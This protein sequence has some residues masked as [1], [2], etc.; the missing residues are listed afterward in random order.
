M[1]WT[2]IRSTLN[3]T[4]LVETRLFEPQLEGTVSISVR[5]RIAPRENYPGDR[6][7]IDFPVVEH[8]LVPVA[9]R[10]MRQPTADE[11][12]GTLATLYEAVEVK[13]GAYGIQLDLKRILEHFWR[14]R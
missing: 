4:L 11:R 5:A 1:P 2:G 7:H 13:P 8:E 14:Y 12:A 10:Q 6:F 3:D 9:L